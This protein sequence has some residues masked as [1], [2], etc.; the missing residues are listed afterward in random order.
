[1]TKPQSNK[2]S[3]KGHCH[4]RY[5]YRYRPVYIYNDLKKNVTGCNY[6]WFQFELDTIP[7]YIYGREPF[8]F[9]LLQKKTTKHE[10]RLKNNAPI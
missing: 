9:C 10:A 5:K 3:I 1:M 4:H 6:F 7:I 2:R 8:L